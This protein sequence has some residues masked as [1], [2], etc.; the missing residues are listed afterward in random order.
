MTR[1]FFWIVTAISVTGFFWVPVLGTHFGEE[2]RFVSLLIQTIC[3]GI[4]LG[5][6]IATGFNLC[7]DS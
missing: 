6:G 3:F 5:I 7:K 4:Q 1:A 2:A